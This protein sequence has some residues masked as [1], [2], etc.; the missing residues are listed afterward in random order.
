LD[1][2]IVVALLALVAH[3]C[4]YLANVSAL[5]TTPPDGFQPTAHFVR[6]PVFLQKPQAQL[7]IGAMAAFFAVPA[8]T[9][10]LRLLMPLLLILAAGYVGWWLKGEHV[11]CHYYPAPDRPL[12]WQNMT[13]NQFA[14]AKFAAMG[15]ID[16]LASWLAAGRRTVAGW[17]NRICPRGNIGPSPQSVAAEGGTNPAAT[18]IATAPSLPSAAPP[19]PSGVVDIIYDYIGMYQH[20]E[21]AQDL[22]LR[23]MHGG[24]SFSRNGVTAQTLW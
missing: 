2:A 12:A 5:T 24:F 3:I 22:L 16:W 8:H 20:L 11:T 13:A 14:A 15:Y 19:L 6:E 23:L 4:F 10:A 21:E 17:V 9:V 1:V 18:Q 7:L